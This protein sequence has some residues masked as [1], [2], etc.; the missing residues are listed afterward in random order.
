MKVKMLTA[1]SGTEYNHGTG[2][3]VDID[4]VLAQRLLDRDMA[5]IPTKAEI[6][7][8]EVDA[9]V[10]AAQRATESASHD[11]VDFSKLTKANIV[12]KAA[13]VHGLELDPALKKD[14][15]LAAI[16]EHVANKASE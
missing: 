7:S 4:D 6:A 16:D 8:A 12:A 13:E 15:M 1:L 14:E 10:V 3:V 9:E 2:A 11:P 5:A